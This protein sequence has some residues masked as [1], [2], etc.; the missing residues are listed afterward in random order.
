[1]P[2]KNIIFDLGGVI[3]DLDFKQT[4]EAFDRLGAH[5]LEQWYSQNKQDPL[6]DQ[7]D[8]GKITPSQ[9]RKTLMQKLNITASDIAFDQAWNAMLLDLPK[10][11]L[12]LIKKLRKQ[13]KVFLFSNTNDIHL[14]EIFNIC[15]RQHGFNSFA[16]Y[17]DKE[18]YSN[19]FGMKK[20]D[21]QAFLKLIHEN[22]LLPQETVHIDDTMQHVLGAKQAGLHAIYLSKEQ[23]IFDIDHLIQAIT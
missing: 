11:R 16:G 17:F 22:H 4:F 7:F 3:L 12:D 8:V 9:F 5:H 2:I 20:P 15:Q 18:Y 1:M 6:F 19:I 21:P 14:K 10:E 13:Y 23:S